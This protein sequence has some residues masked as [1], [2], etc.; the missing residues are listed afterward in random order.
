MTADG[1]THELSRAF[2]VFATQNPIEFEGTYPLPEAQK[3]RFLLKINMGWPNREDELELARKM[4]T[5]DAPETTL[6]EGQVSTVVS[7]EDLI[8]IRN[9]LQKVYIGEEIMS[10]VVDLVRKTRSTE[11]ILAGAGPRATQALVLAS[12]ALAAIEGR[13]FVTP[14]DIKALAL[15][16]LDHRLILRPEFEME[17]ATAA[18]VIARL[19]M[20]VPVPR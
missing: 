3:D 16:V 6:E 11:S 12:R 20:E 4:V 15:P 18:D 9:L 1:V 7:L 2:T 5:G 8:A 13:D 10:Y 17:G 19:L 14:D